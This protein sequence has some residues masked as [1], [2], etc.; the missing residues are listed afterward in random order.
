MCV[1][2]L[3]MN[4]DADF[5]KH[6]WGRQNPKAVPVQECLRIAV[7]TFERFATYYG[8]SEEHTSELQSLAYLVC[9]L[10][11]EKKKN[12][13]QEY[14]RETFLRDLVRAAAADILPYPA[15]GGHMVQLHFTEGHVARKFSP[16]KHIYH[17]FVA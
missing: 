6:S 15:Q 17:T 3:Y 10:L 12:N 1:F 14:P 7:R 16:T 11:L 9:R 2:T 8:R 5:P 13:N 4:F